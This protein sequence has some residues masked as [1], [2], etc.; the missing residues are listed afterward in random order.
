M[1]Q[2]L[3]PISYEDKSWNFLLN[4]AMC[5]ALQHRGNKLPLPNYKV[6]KDIF[7]ESNA[8]TSLLISTL[9]T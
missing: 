5:G 9:G 6:L 8:N 7:V 3:F 4:Q 2:E 1:L